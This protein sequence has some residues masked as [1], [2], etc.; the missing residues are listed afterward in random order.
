MRGLLSFR[1]GLLR[2]PDFLRSEDVS[3]F[4]VLVLFS[5]GLSS[6]ELLSLDR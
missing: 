5:V 3:S 6:M 1:M 4:Q 2:K